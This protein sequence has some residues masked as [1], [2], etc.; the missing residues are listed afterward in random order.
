[1]ESDPVTLHPVKK[2]DNYTSANGLIILLTSCTGIPF[3]DLYLR[4]NS[5]IIICLV[6]NSLPEGFAKPGIL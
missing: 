4:T 5:V 6:H 3:A 2:T 1:M